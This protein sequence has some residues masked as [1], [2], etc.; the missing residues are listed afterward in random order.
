MALDRL[1]RGRKL[2][3]SFGGI[4][5]SVVLVFMAV[6]AAVP[7][8]APSLLPIVDGPSVLPV[9]D[10]HLQEILLTADPDAAI[11]VVLTFWQPEDRALLDGF[12]PHYK[13]QALPMASAQ[14]TPTQLLG[15]TAW[16][17]IR[18]IWYGFDTFSIDLAEGRELVK[19][20]QAT[21]AF[22]VTGAGVTVA[23]I[24]TGVDTL[25]PDFSDPATGESRATNIDV[26]AGPEGT[27]LFIELPNTDDIGHGTH[28]SGTIAGNGALSGGTYTGIAPAARIRMYDTNA[29][30]LIILFE[31]LCAYDD[32][33]AN[34]AETG[35]R[36]ISNSWGGGDGS[37]DRDDPIEVAIRTAYEDGVASVFAAGNSGPRDNTMSRQSVSPYAI[38]VAAITKPL[39]IVG[40]SSRGRPLDW[41]NRDPWPTTHDRDSAL[42]GDLPL[43]RPALSAPG[44]SITAPVPC[45]PACTPTTGYDTLSGTSMATP[46]VSGVLA[47]VLEASPDLSDR[48]SVV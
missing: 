38:G 31:T 33:L 46:H 16:T 13:F 47:L 21:A 10:P 17:E 15:L 48:K 28:V 27:C 1:A 20:P 19:A 42:A 22:G 6:G 41:P 3:H 7:L 44:V 8:E 2:V 23:V 11:L 35:I 32:I 9:V 5:V 40:F 43:F 14:L 45:S 37:F 39:Q 29:G 12:A 18:S 30:L 24:D 34:R 4:A 25:H 36:H 26:W